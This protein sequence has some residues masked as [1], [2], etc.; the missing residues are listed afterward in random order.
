MI[1]GSFA[2]EKYTS[3]QELFR[4][5]RPI[6]EFYPSHDS[7]QDHGGYVIPTAMCLPGE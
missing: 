3:S 6:L 2:L 7:Q 5:S 1:G 4:G